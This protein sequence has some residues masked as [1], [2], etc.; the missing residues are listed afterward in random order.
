MKKPNF[1]YCPECNYIITK[2]IKKYVKFDF[3]C[4]RCKIKKLS[5][6]KRRLKR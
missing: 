4:P 5:S 2:D 3:S 6:F 1:Y